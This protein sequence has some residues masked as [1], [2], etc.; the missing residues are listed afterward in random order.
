MPGYSHQKRYQFVENFDV[1]LHAKNQIYPYLSWCIA[2]ILQTCLGTLSMHSHTH[3]KKYQLNDNFD[4][5]LH[6]KNQHFFLKTLHFKESC[7]P[8]GQKPFGL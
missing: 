1:Y 5:Y 4:V 7:N 3:Q 8:I 6:A 2:K